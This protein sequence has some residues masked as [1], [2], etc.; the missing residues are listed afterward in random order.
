M[1]EC[2]VPGCEEWAG[3]G[4]DKCF[5]HRDR[6][7][8]PPQN[9]KRRKTQKAKRDGPQAAL[10]R[11]LPCAICRRPAEPHHHPSV[12]RGGVDRDTGPLC[13]TH[14]TTGGRP[15][16]FHSTPLSD[17]EAHHGI[18]WSE[19]VEAMRLR[20]ALKT[21]PGDPWASVPY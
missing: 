7:P 19:V 20:V 21:P 6:K 2:I 16:A 10:C 5:R 18:I 17:W 13:R 3:L 8:M 11:T 9:R 12:A 14:H 4:E 15:E 1:I